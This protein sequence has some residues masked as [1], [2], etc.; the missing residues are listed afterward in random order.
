VLSVLGVGIWELSAGHITLGGLLAFLVFLAQLSSPVQ[1]LG[2]RSNS[3]FAAAECIIDL[4]D[5]HPT[6]ITPACPT[7]LDRPRGHLRLERSASPTPTPQ[8][9]S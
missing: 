2:H 1:G 6:V 7:P 8:P 5:Q 9:M 3:L 4:L